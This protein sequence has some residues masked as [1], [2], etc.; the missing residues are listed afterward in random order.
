MGRGRLVM[1]WAFQ[2]ERTTLDAR[3]LTDLLGGLGYQ[4]AGLPGFELAFWSETLESCTNVG[5]VWE[6][7]KRLRNLISDVTEID[8][9]LV[10]GAVLDLSSGAPKRCHFVEAESC[11]I[12][13]SCCSATLTV[14]PPA[15]LSAEQLVEWNNRRAEQEYQVRLEEQRA[16]LEPAFREPRAVK[17]LML[18]KRDAHTG[19]TL[20][21]LYELAEGHPSRRKDFMERF[22]IVEA[23]F[24]RFSDAVHNPVVSGDLARHAY[25]DKPKTSH[26]M[27]FAEA[28]SFVFGVAHRWLTSLRG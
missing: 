21:K 8:P 28:Q 13:I 17:A 23:E 5:G 9:E 22:G 6:E 12:G 4:Q 1:K 18:L 14:S 15:G 11:M 26:P 16:K 24:R 2:I 25:E 10:L 20:Y 3:N 19:E 27:S 7:A